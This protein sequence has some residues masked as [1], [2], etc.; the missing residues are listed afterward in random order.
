M[1][2]VL[3]V[4][5]TKT[6]GHLSQSGPLHLLV[7]KS[8]YHPDSA[9][10]EIGIKVSVCPSSLAT[11]QQ[12]APCNERENLLRYLRQ[13]ARIG[14]GMYVMHDIACMTWMAQGVAHGIRSSLA[15]A[16]LL[17]GQG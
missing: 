7:S 4:V 10:I 15:D 9:T 5:A 1:R 14:Y 13:V 6:R 17:Q 16:S 11:F 12:I 2:A 3:D 8:P